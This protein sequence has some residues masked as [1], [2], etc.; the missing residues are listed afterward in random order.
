MKRAANA[1]STKAIPGSCEAAKIIMPIKINK[2]TVTKKTG[3]KGFYARDFLNI[4]TKATW[5]SPVAFKVPIYYYAQILWDTK[6]GDWVQI[7]FQGKKGW[8][9]TSFK[10]YWYEKDP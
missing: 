8:Y 5:D 4:R 2:P 6:N 1:N 9:K 7:E 3:S 10:K